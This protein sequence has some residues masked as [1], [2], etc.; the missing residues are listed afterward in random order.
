MTS[1]ATTR[2]SRAGSA[3]DAFATGR[4]SRTN[5]RLIANARSTDTIVSGLSRP[6]RCLRRALSIERIWFSKITES[7]ARPASR[8][9]TT[10]SEGY[11]SSSIFDVMAATIVIGLWRFEIS[12]WMTRAGRVFWISAPTVGSKETQ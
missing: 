10:T 9:R 4:Y 8:A 7:F 1:G 5:P 2:P 11:G 12:F 6:I 3:C